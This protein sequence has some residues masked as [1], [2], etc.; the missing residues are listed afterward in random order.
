MTDA[1]GGRRGPYAKSRLARERILAAAAEVFSRSGLRSGWLREVAI[2]AQMSEAGVLYH[3]PSKE[4]LLM[5]LLECRDAWEASR[6]E[7]LRFH[8]RALLQHATN[9]TAEATATGQT[10][11]SLYL[12]LA[13]QAAAPDHPAHDHFHG[14]RVRI[15]GA[16]TEAFQGLAREDQLRTTVDPPLL[17]SQLLALLDGIQLQWRFSPGTV[18]VRR[19]IESFIE[20][21]VKPADAG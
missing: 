12:D 11:A 15:H 18:D 3:Y 7:E 6:L 8:P 20:L 19:T 13:P 2:L 16:V 17:A 14:R 21:H 10:V 4:V 5:A 9:V 1:R